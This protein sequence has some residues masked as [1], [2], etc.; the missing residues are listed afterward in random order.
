MNYI[1]LQRLRKADERTKVM[2]RDVI[3]ALG[4]RNRLA[5]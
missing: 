1:T 2:T 3:H 5:S 4:Y